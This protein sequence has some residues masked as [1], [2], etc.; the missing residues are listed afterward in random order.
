MTRLAEVQL[1]LRD[2]VVSNGKRRVALQLI[3]GADPSKRLVIHQRNYQ[4][5]LIEALRTKFPATEWLVGT[6][7]LT[8]AATQF[9][10]ECP[11]T[12]PCI[13]DFGVTFPDFLATH[14]QH[15]DYIRDFAR[16]EWFVG[17]AAIAVDE[18]PLDGLI[19]SSIDEDSLPDL[20]LRLQSGTHYL[21]TNWPV[22][23]LMMFYLN[24]TAPDQLALIPCDLGIE[25]RGARG[26]FQIKRLEAGD[27]IFRQS[28][29]SGLSIGAAAE[30]AF[31]VSRCF[32]PAHSFAALLESGLVT[33]IRQPQKESS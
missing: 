30:R 33:A 13:A 26:E 3:G 18:S 8:E 6:G 20:I 9:I 17:K 15:V 32:D 21:N 19:F 14:V 1:H 16:L 11:P 12:A 31:E 24:D 7:L 23:E 28:V 4:S 2:A 27:L 25:I 5:S 10:Q 29:S 22:D